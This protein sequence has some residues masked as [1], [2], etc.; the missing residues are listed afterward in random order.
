MYKVRRI[1]RRDLGR[2][3]RISRPGNDVDVDMQVGVLGIEAVDHRGDDPALTLGLG[4]VHAAAIFGAAFAEEALQVDVRL[5]V[6][7][8]AASKGQSGKDSEQR[9]LHRIAVPAIARTICFWK[10]M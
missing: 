8:T 10:T 4:D 3:L 6:V 2:Q 1:A 7:L 9:A 5:A